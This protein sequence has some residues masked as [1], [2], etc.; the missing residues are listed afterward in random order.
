MYDNG[1]GWAI[2]SAARKVVEQLGINT[3]KDKILLIAIMSIWRG[4][5]TIGNLAP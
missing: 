3:S 1:S 4:P 2:Y 5:S